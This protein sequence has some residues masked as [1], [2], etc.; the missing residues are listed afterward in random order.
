M[1]EL[2]S[3]FCKK[4]I[5]FKICY[6]IVKEKILDDVTHSTR[7]HGADPSSFLSSS[8]FSSLLEKNISKNRVPR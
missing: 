4:I 8:S 2:R 5:D 1:H 3:F 7:N 6:M